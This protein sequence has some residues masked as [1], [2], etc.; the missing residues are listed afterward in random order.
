MHGLNEALK[1]A[2]RENKKF[3]W[4]FDPAYIVFFLLALGAFKI[5]LSLY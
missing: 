3:S 5:A 1:E 2:E 4:G